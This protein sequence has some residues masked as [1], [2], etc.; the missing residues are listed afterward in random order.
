[1]KIQG[2]DFISYLVID[3]KYLEIEFNDLPISYQSIFEKFEICMVWYDEGLK[4]KL[5]EFYWSNLNHMNFDTI[6]HK[7]HILPPSIL[8]NKRFKDEIINNHE[9]FRILFDRKSFFTKQFDSNTFNKLS[10]KNILVLNQEMKQIKISYRLKCLDKKLEK[11]LKDLISEFNKML[12]DY[13]GLDIHSVSFRN[14]PKFSW[15]ILNWLYQ[16]E[17]IEGINNEK[18]KEISCS[19]IYLSL[20]ED[21]RDEMTKHI[22]KLTENRYKFN[23]DEEHLKSWGDTFDGNHHIM[24]RFKVS[25]KVIVFDIGL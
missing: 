1:M 22:T 19:P 24:F 15:N 21:Q 6:A 10:F 8:E 17:I 7:L 11:E 18:I 20:D 23:K 3:F 4:N 13:M 2:F 16:H 12:G 14:F 9:K 25:F 5:E